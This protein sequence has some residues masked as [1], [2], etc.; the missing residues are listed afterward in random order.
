MQKNLLVEIFK[1]MINSIIPLEYKLFTL[2]YLNLKSFENLD[3]LDK[4]IET[5]DENHKT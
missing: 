4:I 3:S 1:K 2:K 5:I